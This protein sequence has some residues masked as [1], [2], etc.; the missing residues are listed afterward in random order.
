MRIKLR[1][2][3]GVYEKD[4]KGKTYRVGGALV[5]LFPVGVMAAAVARDPKTL[6]RWETE[7]GWPVPQWNVPDKRCKRWYSEK[8]VLAAHEIYWGLSRDGDRGFS[9]S[10]HFPLQ[11]FVT[12]VRRVF[13]TVDA[14]AVA[15]KE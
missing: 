8:Q 9:H 4:F 10:P 3:Q 12:N 6:R 1:T 2:P 11:Q 14:D 15:T 7:I 13:Y 5:V